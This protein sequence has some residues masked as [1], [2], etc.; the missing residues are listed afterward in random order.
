MSR[1]PWWCGIAR[2]APWAIALSDN[3]RRQ[4]ITKFSVEKAVQPAGGQQP[5]GE[6]GQPSARAGESGSLSALAQAGNPMIPLAWRLPVAGLAPGSYRA[7][8]TVR[9]SSGATALREARFQLE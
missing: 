4:L 1:C 5:P 8:F 6:A 9:D 3:G 2:G 7:E